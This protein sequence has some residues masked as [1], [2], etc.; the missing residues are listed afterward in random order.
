VRGIDDVAFEVHPEIRLVEG[1]R[2]AQGALE[3]IAGKAARDRYKDLNIG[4]EVTM[5]RA[6]NRLFKV[7]GI[8]EAGGSALESEILAPRTMISDSYNRRLVSSVVLRL[9]DASLADTAIEYIDGSAVALEARRETKYYADLSQKTA[10]IVLLTSILTA[11]MA[12]GAAFAVANT[13]YA[14]VDARRREIAMLRTIG[15]P[16]RA[17]VASFVVEGLMIC[18]VA[19]AAG[20]L[21]VAAYFGFAGR[22]DDY[23]S[24][25]TW[26]VLAYDDRLTPG[27]A[28]VCAGLAVVVGVLGAFAPAMRAARVQVITALR[29][30]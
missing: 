8:F 20:L 28:M 25:I 4:D 10:E 15:F 14:A 21:A 2:F 3:C 30:A 27:I 19:C 12:F 18:L 22:Q 17:I 16:R 24:D 9:R 23:L 6:A 13:M 11:L 7:V 5:G 26:T 29:R 1:R